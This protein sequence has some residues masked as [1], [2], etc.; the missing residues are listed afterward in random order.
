MKKALSVILLAVMLLT[1]SLTGCGQDTGTS[2]NGSDSSGSAIAS[3]T[4][5]NSD[6]EWLTYTFVD[7]RN[8]IQPDGESDLDC[9]TPYLEEKFHIKAERVT[10]GEG[11]PVQ[12]RLNMMI[13]AGTLPDVIN[14]SSPDLP[15]LVP[16]LSG[17]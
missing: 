7:V 13:A 17:F 9:I 10:F 3:E 1:G 5:D 15:W 8:S 14:I 4:A 2:G 16:Q 11:E 12:Q 6:L